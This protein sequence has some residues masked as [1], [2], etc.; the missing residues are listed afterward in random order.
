MLRTHI[1]ENYQSNQIYHGQAKPCFFFNDPA[2]TEIYTLSLHD[3]LPICAQSTCACSAGNICRRKNG[4]GRWGRRL[5]RKSTRLNSSH[6]NISD[7][8]F[9]LKKRITGYTDTPPFADISLGNSEETLV[10]S[11]QLYI[12]TVNACTK[13]LRH[14]CL[15]A[16]WYFFL[17]NAA[18]TEI[19]TFSLPDA[20]PF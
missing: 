16:V 10:D 20:F 19:S 17:K 11:P 13:L 8:V 12:H 7:A 2:T 18:A 3:A 4:S 9:C 14:S 6:R 15:K 1:C 5:D